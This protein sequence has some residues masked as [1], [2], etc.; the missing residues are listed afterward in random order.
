MAQ[1]PQT[2][3]LKPEALWEA[4]RRGDLGAVK[5][6]IESG[7][8]V[9][10]ATHYGASALSFAADRGH[11]DVVEY[12]LSKQA[13]PNR[14]DSFYN[15]TPMIWA[16]RANRYVIMRAL[17]LAGANDVDTMLEKAI[18][19]DDLEAIEHITTP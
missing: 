3:T 17:V 8:D 14:K 7:V 9:D 10:S 18:S 16:I 5:I 11:A 19:Q 4:A 1:S 13:D 2:Q 6:T 12:L 15:A